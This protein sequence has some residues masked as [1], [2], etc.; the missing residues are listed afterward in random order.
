MAAQIIC[1]AD[2]FDVMYSKRSY[3]NNLAKDYILDE[4]EQCA[5]KQFDWQIAKIMIDMINDGFV[6]RTEF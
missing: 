2:A 3:R 5:G 4:L 6:D 1:A